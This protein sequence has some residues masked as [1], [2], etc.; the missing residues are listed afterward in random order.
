VTI[1]VTLHVLVSAPAR[2]IVVEML[3]VL[4]A[5]MMMVT[6]V[7]NSAYVKKYALRDA[8]SDNGFEDATISKIGCALHLSMQ[9]VLYLSIALASQPTNFAMTYLIALKHSNVPWDFRLKVARWLK[10][11]G[12]FMPARRFEPSGLV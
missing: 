5:M 9:I 8:L 7:N 4:L 2:V 1:I 12:R 11:G 10:P 3:I 6:D